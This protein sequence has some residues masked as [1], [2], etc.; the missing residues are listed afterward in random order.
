M[1][2]PVVVVVAMQSELVHLVPAGTPYAE[3][4]AG[5]WNE[6]HTVFGPIPVIAI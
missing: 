5:I 3:L 6:T 1:V 2:R 4:T